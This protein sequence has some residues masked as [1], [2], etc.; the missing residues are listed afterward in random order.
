MFLPSA[1]RVQ[2]KREARWQPVEPT[3]EGGYRRWPLGGMRPV[4]LQDGSAGPLQGCPARRGRPVL[5][6]VI[7]LLS[8]TTRCRTG[9]SR[10]YERRSCTHNQ[11][12]AGYRLGSNYATAR[13]GT[14]WS[15]QAD[16]ASSLD[17]WPAVVQRPLTELVMCPLRRGNVDPHVIASTNFR[18]ATVRRNRLSSARHDGIST[19]IS[20]EWATR[21]PSRR[22]S[23]HESPASRLARRRPPVVRGPRTQES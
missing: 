15:S 12:V 7:E 14:P 8:Q 3:A 20:S 9:P 18:S 17:R 22:P 16:P 19:N 21:T 1:R 2:K 23:R 11:P 5:Y 13:P 6:I 4:A 10:E